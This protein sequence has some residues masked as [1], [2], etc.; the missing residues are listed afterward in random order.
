[1]QPLV[2][3]IEDDH[4]N[5][6]LV[7]RVLCASGFN[8]LEA[9]TATEGIALAEQYTPDL[10]LMDINLP[11]IDGITATRQLRQHPQLQHIPIIALTANVMQNVI[12]QALAAGCNGYIEKPIQIDRLVNDVNRF[13]EPQQRDE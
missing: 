11:E 7:R 3:Y 12:N 1:M 8:L 13:L 5:M 6:V 10:I 4:D 2:L 9:S